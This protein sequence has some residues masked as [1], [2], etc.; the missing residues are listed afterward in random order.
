MAMPS[1]QV[2]HTPFTCSGVV[3]NA[4][5]EIGLSYEDKAIDIF[6]GQQRSAEYLAINSKG[7]VPVLRLNDKV[8][9][10]LPAILRMLNDRYG[11]LFGHVDAADALADLIWFAD[12]LHG[13]LRMAFMPQRFTTG[14]PQ[15]VRDSNSHR[16][17][18]DMR[19]IA[20]RV[21]KGPY[22]FG[23]DWTIV[24]VYTVWLFGL[25]DRARID[26]AGWPDLSTYVDRVMS[27]P[28]FQRAQARE[29]QALASS[30]IILP[31][32]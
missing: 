27:R 13:A 12:T 23:S 11:R 25:A 26:R 21:S 24:D 14:D 32:G 16:L 8:F 28:S 17:A 19:A 2:Y 9:T 4:L 31:G 7:K 10:E 5:E 18:P 29:E 6:R 20:Q 15:G 1:V 30:G 3:L 22:W